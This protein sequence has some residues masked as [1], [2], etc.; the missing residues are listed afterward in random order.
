L[1]KELL[2]LNDYPSLSVKATLKAGKEK[3]TTDIIA[4]VSDKYPIFGTVSI[5]NFGVSATSKNRMAASL[6]VG[7]T[8]TSGDLIKLYGLIGL[9]DINPKNLSYGRAEYVIPVGGLGTQ[10]GTY[11]SNTA[12]NAAGND[13]FALLGLNGKADVIGV[14]VTHPLVKRY[15]EALSLRIGSEY[16]SLH[17]NLLGNT[18]DKD[19]I[20]KITAGISYESTDKFMGRN[21][22]SFGYARGLGGILG[23]TSN[24]ATNPG[25]SYPGANNTFNKLSLD[26]VRIQKLPGYNHLIASGGFQYSPDRMFSEERMQIGGEGSVRGFSPGKLSGDNG[27]FLSLEL[28]SSP[29]FPEKH[30]FNQTVGDTIKF[31]LFSD[32]GG[33][34]NTNPRPSEMTES[35]LSS[36]GAGVRLYGANVFTLKLDWAIPGKQGG[37]GDFTLKDNQV[38]FQTVVSF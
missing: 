3:G 29:L 14:Y 36:I 20:R 15:N 22:V 23:G 31:V 30:I 26:M 34:V 18:Q 2:L 24:N 27:Y 4:S 19:E 38:Y 28:L 33:V 6:N 8:I 17:D 21:F 1:E 12:Y 13:S 10:F 11:Y 9:D 37:Y 7:N 5:D 25:P 16:I 32:F 35:C